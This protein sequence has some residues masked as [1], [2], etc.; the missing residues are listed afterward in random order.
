MAVKSSLVPDLT[1]WLLVN[2]C[3]YMITSEANDT[4]LFAVASWR[5]VQGVC[6]CDS[7]DVVLLLILDLAHL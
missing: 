3:F 4:A 2:R 6:A 7:V 5:H 1:E